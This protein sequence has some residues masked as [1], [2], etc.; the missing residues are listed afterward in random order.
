[1]NG[2][3]IAGLIWVALRLIFGAWFPRIEFRDPKEHNGSS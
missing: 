2:W 3:I 1:M